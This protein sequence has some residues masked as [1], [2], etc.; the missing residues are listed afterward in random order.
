LIAEVQSILLLARMALVPWLGHSIIGALEHG[1]GAVDHTVRTYSF[2]K[3]CSLSSI[4]PK[5]HHFLPKNYETKK[6][7]KESKIA[8]TN[9]TKK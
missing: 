9:K 5:M 7:Q 6:V 4:L 3:I 2:S 8:Q 1:L